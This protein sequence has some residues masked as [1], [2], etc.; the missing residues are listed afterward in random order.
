[1]IRRVILNL[2]YITDEK[3][4][5]VDF[6]IDEYIVFIQ[7]VINTLWNHRVSKGMYVDKG[8]YKNIK[9]NLTERYKQ[10]AGKQAL[11][12]VKSQREKERKTKPVIHKKTMEL[13]GRF[14]KIEEGNNSFDMW[15]KLSILNGKPIHIPTK[16]HYHFNKFYNKGWEM[17]KSCRLR[18]TMKGLFLDVFFEKEDIDFKVEGDIVGLDLGYRKLA[19]L[20][21][22]QLIGNEFKDE[23]K[24]YYKR[25]KSHLIVRE[26]IN[27]ELKDIDFSKM[28]ILVIEDLKNVKKGKRKKNTRH[29]NRLLSH[30]AYHH[31]RTKLE[32]L[33][34]ENRVQLMKVNPY[35]T[36]KACNRCGKWGIRRNERFV[37]NQCGWKVDADY[38]ASLNIRD[39]F[40][41]LGVY[42][43]R[44]KVSFD[45]TFA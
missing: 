11:Q 25:K 5:K 21:D 35:G 14:V 45:I 19:V 32:M 2:N 20:S 42:G 16:R 3:K 24:K 17:K 4:E 7:K 15:I 36:S 6:L 8:L 41:S 44:S 1:M 26:H 9:S 38:N 43:L 37:C 34:E 12:I 23:I 10:C 29:T 30:W 33:C 40:I 39:R 22:G 27:R 28:N 18:N 13:D 31:A